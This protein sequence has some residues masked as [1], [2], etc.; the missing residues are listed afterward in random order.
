MTFTTLTYLVFLPAVFALYWSLRQRTHQNLLLVAVSY[1]FYGWWDFRFCLLMM[2]SSLVDYTITLRI[3]SSEDPKL[4]RALLTFACLVNFGL[5]GFFKYFN[6]FSESFVDLLRQLGIEAHPFSVKVILP[7]GI[8]FYTFQTMSYTIDVYRRK[9]PASRGIVEYLAFVSFFPHLVAGPIMRAIDFLPQF[10][11]E[12]SFDPAQAIDGCRQILWGVVKKMV[13]ADNL[14]RTVDAAYFQP[15][16]HSG[17]QLAFATVCFAFQIYC[18]FSAYADIAS[19]SAKLLGFRLVRNFAY[20]YFS[21]SPSEFWRRW[22]IS[23]S[24]WFRDYVYFALGGSHVGR[25]RRVLNVMLTF[26][27]SGLWHGASWNFV[28]W[29]ALNGALL[30]PGLLLSGRSGAGRVDDVPGGP[31]LIPSLRTLAAMLGTFVLICTTWV[32]F[33]S[34]TLADSLLILRKIALES[35]QPEAWANVGAGAKSALFIPLFVLVEW[36]RRRHVHPLESLGGSRPL[37]FALYTAIVW[38]TLYLSAGSSS[39]FIYFQF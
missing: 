2:F 38:A 11:R 39:P 18:D 34:A 12:R 16:S 1:F 15:S 4:R 37:R 6:F 19:G 28:I 29:G 35:F 30:V 20:P 17:P 5:L 3:S 36:L 21:R 8:S 25:L 32:F 7:A 24:T 31:E 23:L 14:S 33:R 10:Q 26:V 13:L 9:M 27:L 22:H